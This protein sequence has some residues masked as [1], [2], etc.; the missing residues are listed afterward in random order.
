MK[1]PSWFV[2]IASLVI[3]GLVTSAAVGLQQQPEPTA[4][5][6]G[7]LFAD[8][9]VQTSGEYVACCLQTYKLAGDQVQTEVSKLRIEEAK[10]TDNERGLAPCVVM[11]LDETVLDNG[12]YQSYLYDNGLDHSTDR[13]SK[14]VTDER[15]SIRLVPGAKDFIERVEALG[16]PVVYITNRPDSLRDVT[17]ATLAQWGVN[18][19][20]LNDP[21][22]CRLLLEVNGE[23]NKTARRDLVRAKYRILGLVGDQLSD[24]ADEFSPRKDNTV[25]GRKDA[26]YEYST[27]WGTRW[28][29][30]PNPMYGAYQGVLRGAPELH[31]RRPAK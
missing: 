11:D 7:L 3:V 28:F 31:L 20:G 4:Q 24:F 22:T 1:S 13:F 12:T 16:L 2:R 6:R 5:Q 21:Q 18:T 9:W 14:W 25:I 17:I 23:S 29:I 26:V 19:Q 30:L 8:L 10:L 27:M 15:A